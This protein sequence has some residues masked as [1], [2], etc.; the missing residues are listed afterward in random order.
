MICRSPHGQPAWTALLFVLLAARLVG[1]SSRPPPPTVV[2]RPVKTIT[3]T[4]GNAALVRT[5]PGRVDAA[6]RAELAFQVPGLLVSLP[7][8]EG[9]KVAEGELIGQL[10]QEDFQNPLNAAQAQLDQ[11]RARLRSL[12]AGERPEERA[13]RESNVR[14]AEARLANARVEHERNVRLR[15]TR[16]ITQAE[17]DLT[18]TTYRVAQEEYL[19][20]RQ[21][22][23]K[24]TIA[25][26]EDLEA[27]EADVRGL[28]ARVVEASLR[29]ADATLRAPY[30]G[31]I[32]RRLV[33]EN[34]NVQAKQPIV[35]FQDVEEIEII[36]D[37]PET[38][39][40]AELR[41][42]E[43]VQL[44][45]E[46]TAAPGLEFPVRLREVA[47]V[48]DPATQTFQVRAVMPAP[49]GVRILPGMTGTITATFRRAA[50][51]GERLLVPISAVQRT[52][53]G[54]KQVAWVVGSDQTVASRAVE[55]GAAAGGQIEI[56]SGL[57]P[58][59]R[60]AVTG[61]T[62]LRE[63]MKVRDLGDALGGRQP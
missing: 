36:V 1:C 47:Q 21:L 62:F 38:V 37:V 40:A 46:F 41:T 63:G 59:D 29:L 11:A 22:L 57:A 34:Q 54:D 58:G 45:A 50:V 56:V 6:R 61:T 53:A 10:R 33:E 24:A 8:K 25:R 12:Q 9:Q 52:P 28:E 13:R 14:A 60:I 4:P 35:Q 31:V 42:A 30:D 15:S 5:F 2:G 44:T 32:A 27:Q 26:T 18:E 43:F 17:Y 49:Q 7:V 39:M 51:L 23:E 19:A 3:V 55:V 20:A 48:A 16:A